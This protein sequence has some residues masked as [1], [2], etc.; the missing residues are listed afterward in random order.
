MKKLIYGG[1]LLTL[2]GISY[3][4]CSKTD[5]LVDNQN[6]QDRTESNKPV[7]SASMNKADGIVILR[8]D[9]R[10]KKFDCLDGWGLCNCEWFPDAPWKDIQ[11]QID[12]QNNTM[13]M[14]SES[15]RDNG[16]DTLTIDEDF[17][18]PTD[19]ALESGYNSVI[20]KEGQYAKD[21]NSEV[22]VNVDLN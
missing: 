5:L 14:V 12:D 3:V 18:L 2:V 4:S 20:I 6:D 1:L 13:T 21:R 22:I 11:T 17:T 7:N 15:F 9:Q 8:C 19:F 10:R 16:F